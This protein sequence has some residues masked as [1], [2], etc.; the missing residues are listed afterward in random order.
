MKNIK[1]CEFASEETTCFQASL[2]IDGRKAA[3]VS[4]G[5]TGGGNSYYFDDH[6]LER[7]FNEHCSGLPPYELPGGLYKEPDGSPMM[8]DQDADGVVNDILIAKDLL[9]QQ[10][11]LCKNALVFKIRAAP[12]GEY[13]SVRDKSTDCRKRL[14][15]RYGSEIEYFL[16]DRI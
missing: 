3:D 15:E 16:N 10:K 12:D 5:G 13:R 6:D 11:K 8:V 7:R 1:I 4:N 14:E 2:W 9:K